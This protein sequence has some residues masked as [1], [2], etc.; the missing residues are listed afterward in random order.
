MS[1][2]SG[3]KYRLLFEPY[4][5]RDMSA[6]RNSSSSQSSHQVR[7]K[8]VVAC[9]LIVLV[10]TLTLVMN[11]VENIGFGTDVNCRFRQFLVNCLRK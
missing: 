7:R 9:L 10:L 1:F 2:A 8:D 3:R 6:E 4:V 5:S 11:D